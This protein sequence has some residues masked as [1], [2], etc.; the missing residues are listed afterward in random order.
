MQIPEQLLQ[1]LEGI[2]GFD[3]NGF[4][5]IHSCN[6][7]VTSVRYNPLK[8]T[9]DNFQLS[10]AA[11]L[12]TPDSGLQT[13]NSPFTIHDKIPWSTHGY[14][15]LQRP[16]FTFDPLFHA[17]LYYVQE[18]S[19]MFL[20][21]VLRQTADISKPLRV[22]D[23]CAAPGGK[24]TLI[25]SLISKDSLLVSNE[26]IKSRVGVLEENI[27]K[28]GAENVVV[29]NNDPSSYAKLENYFDI[30]VI[31]APC[32]G[33]GLFR[34]D[35]E[36]ISEWSE[37]NVQLCSQR[38]QRIIADTWPALKEDGILIYSTCSYS[39]EEDEEILDWMME[40]FRVEGVRCRVEEEW[41]IVETTSSGGDVFG[42]RFYPDKLK[43]EGFFIAAL[44]K[45][46]GS[47]FNGIK[48]GKNRIEK[49]SKSEEALVTHW[50][51]ERQDMIFFKQQD[52]IIALPSCFQND[53]PVL[54]SALYIKKAGI[55][56]GKLAGKDL[57]PDQQLALS[58]IISTN[59]VS[60]PL[61]RE[62]AIQYL[63]KEEVQV[64]TDHKGWALVS[65]E[66]HSLGWIKMLPNRINNYYP[67]E[68]RI[69]KRAE[70]R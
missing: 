15:L 10:I 14:Y 22:L 57:I 59:I 33:S 41:N 67:K 3:R 32:S 24:S 66:G 11:P 40:G 53:I 19:S 21:Q 38:Q 16:S 55:R 37:S 23:L 9:I 47:A 8:L 17:G 4:I 42:Y 2:K 69:L 34:R 54:Q 35:P 27:V 52:D 30:I 1:S 45:K 48:P 62:Q 5:K 68:W 25:Q 63:R 12:L 50:L 36:A 26:V 65:Y 49:I 29:T 64:S 7:Q 56:I 6:E 60:V 61:N 43:G 18:A 44:R 28:W 70:N 46:E 13:P 39:R 51:Q 20:E 58:N 31:D